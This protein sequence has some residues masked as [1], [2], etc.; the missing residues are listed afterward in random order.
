MFSQPIFLLTIVS[1]FLAFGL[2][3]AWFAV[4]A[5]RRLPRV[6]ALTLLIFPHVFRTVGLV[7]VVPQVVDGRLPTDFTI[8][9][10]AGDLLAVFLA[11]V[12]LVALRGRWR[13]ALPL[14]WLFNL[15][16]TADLTFAYVAGA[17]FHFPDYQVG[18]AWFIPALY[19]PFLF[20]TH[21]LIF[22]LLVRR[23]TAVV[24]DIPQS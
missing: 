23:H 12:A 9:A 7:F 8:P 2:L 22:W 20:I 1:N 3:A 14:V 19:V 5:L 4:P 10:S 11:F 15:A 16:G 18:V 21:G 13:S 17:R 6:Q 24:T